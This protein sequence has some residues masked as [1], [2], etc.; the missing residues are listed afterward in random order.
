M[1]ASLVTDREVQRSNRY[2]QGYYQGYNCNIS[3]PCASLRFGAPQT[4][5]REYES[6]QSLLKINSLE[7][8]NRLSPK[9]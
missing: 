2:N 9:R 4:E 7:R 1:A 8:F 3:A 5:S 6:G